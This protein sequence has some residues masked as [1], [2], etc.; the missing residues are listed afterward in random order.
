MA[1]RLFKDMDL[2]E[3]RIER[4]V[5]D[6]Q[7]KK[8]AVWGESLPFAVERRDAYAREIRRRRRRLA[9]ARQDYAREIKRRENEAV[10]AG[11]KA[12]AEGQNE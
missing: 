6:D 2:A 1:T 10:L 5:W 9:R 11:R 3:L 4:Q 12:T 7:I 8:A